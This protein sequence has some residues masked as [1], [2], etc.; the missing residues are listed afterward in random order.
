MNGEKHVE[1]S[2]QPSL[3]RR[4]PIEELVKGIVSADQA[5]DVA[6]Q[7]QI[8]AE[9]GAHIR[10]N[11]RAQ[12]EQ[13]NQPAPSQPEI[14]SVLTRAEEDNHSPE[15][16]PALDR[17]IVDD[18]HEDDYEPP[19]A[20]EPID[21]RSPIESPPF[22]PAP[23]ESIH[24]IEEQSNDVNSRQASETI[25]EPQAGTEELPSR[26]GSLPKLNEVTKHLEL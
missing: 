10:E 19:E 5:L 9:A 15:Y 14:D 18:V 6:L 24:E 4:T 11:E 17:S 20:H 26:N 16:S 23:P 1:S 7:E 12:P 8:Q 3:E 2:P 25:M 13:S 22:S 21:T